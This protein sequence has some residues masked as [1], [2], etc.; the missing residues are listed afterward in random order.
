MEWNSGSSK[1]K[2]MYKGLEV[3]D[4]DDVGLC[5][6]VPMLRAQREGEGRAVV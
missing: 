3:K 5:K 1:R 4:S 2:S 6:Q